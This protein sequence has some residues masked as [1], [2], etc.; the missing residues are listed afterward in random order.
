MP[1][2]TTSENPARSPSSSATHALRSASRIPPALLAP[3]I[4]SR[5]AANRSGSAPRVDADPDR[6]QRRS[7]DNQSYALTAMHRHRNRPCSLEVWERANSARSWF[8][9]EGVVRRTRQRARSE[10]NLRCG[11]HRADGPLRARPGSVRPPIRSA[12][13]VRIARRDR[14]VLSRLSRAAQMRNLSSLGVAADQTARSAAIA[15]AQASW[16]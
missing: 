11:R 15:E 12:P 14:E 6:A 1:R 5:G 8:R 3:L 10:R 7:Q 13:V 2:A 16:R 4:I 9:R